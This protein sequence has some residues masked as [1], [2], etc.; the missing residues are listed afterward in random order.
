MANNAVNVDIDADAL[1]QALGQA[2][3]AHGTG[4][5]G[6]RVQLLEGTNPDEWK[7]WIRRFEMVERSPQAEGAVRGHSRD[8]RQGGPG[9]QGRRPR[10]RTRRRRGGAHLRTLS[11]KGSRLS[12]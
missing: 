8:S 7:D 2:L 11:N 12:F 9:H 5:Q 4:G 6:K 3:A 10:R 1:G